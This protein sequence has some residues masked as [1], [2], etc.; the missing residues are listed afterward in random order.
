[1]PVPPSGTVVTERIHM[2]RLRSSDV[3]PKRSLFPTAFRRNQRDKFVEGDVLGLVHATA[4]RVKTGT[5]DA[6][7]FADFISERGTARELLQ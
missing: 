7:R 3:C 2:R 4:G 6:R 1:M 5:L